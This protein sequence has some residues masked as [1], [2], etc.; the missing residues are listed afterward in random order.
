[1]GIKSVVFYIL[2]ISL[3][4]F[5]VFRVVNKYQTKI[6]SLGLVRISRLGIL[7]LSAIKNVVF[8]NIKCML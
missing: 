4:K 1:M 5:W 2:Y 7:K 6:Y 8:D 3:I